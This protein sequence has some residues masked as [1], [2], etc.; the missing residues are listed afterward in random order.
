[1]MNSFSQPVGSNLCKENFLLQELRRQTNCMQLTPGQRGKKLHEVA[2]K[3]GYVIKTGR[4][5]TKCK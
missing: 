3:R 5:P 2:E 1:M 4:L